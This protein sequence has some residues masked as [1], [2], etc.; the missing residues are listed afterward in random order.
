MCHLQVGAWAKISTGYSFKL[1]A[2]RWC[3]IWQDQW[4]PWS[5]AHCHVLFVV[6]Q[7][8]CLMW[9]HAGVHAGRSDALWDLEE[10][11]WPKYCMQKMQIHNHN[12]SQPKPRWNIV[13]SKMLPN[14]WLTFGRNWTLVGSVDHSPSLYCSQVSPPPVVGLVRKKS[15]LLSL[16]IDSI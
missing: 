14:G 10:W 3:C 7:V 2:S 4:I 1:A 5:C 15:L 8:S 16:C 9:C 11:W 6:K 12:M 13:H